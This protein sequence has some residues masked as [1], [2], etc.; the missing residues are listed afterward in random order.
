[1]LWDTCRFRNNKERGMKQVLLLLG[2]VALLIGP[3]CAYYNKQA[4]PE[5]LYTAPDMDAAGLTKD[6]YF[7]QTRYGFRLLSIPI[8]VPEANKMISG[9]IAEHKA[10]GVTDIEIDFSEFNAFIFSVPKVR[11]KGYV[12]T[13]PENP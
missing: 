5:K 2:L 11:V 4:M 13:A 12:V 9:I 3:G 7:V 6:E 1:M 8:S 10:K